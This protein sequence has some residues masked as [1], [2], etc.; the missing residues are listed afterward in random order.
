M[1][2]ANNSIAVVNKKIE[3]LLADAGVDG[4]HIDDILYLLGFD[5][6]SELVIRLRDL[7][8]RSLVREVTGG[9]WK[10]ADPEALKPAIMNGEAGQVESLPSS[11]QEALP[12][13]HLPGSPKFSSYKNTLQ[14]YCQ[15]K[16]LAVPDYKAD[17]ESNGLVGSV[18]FS[19]NTVRSTEVS[20]S[21]KEAH[22]RA[23]FAALV[24]LGY[25]KDAS[26]ELNANNQNKSKKPAETAIVAKPVAKPVLKPGIQEH[27]TFKTLL[28]EVAEKKK[29]PFPTYRTVSVNNKSYFSTVTFDKEEYKCLALY[30]RQEDAEQNAAQVALISLVAAP[31][32]E[33][34]KRKEAGDFVAP[35]AKQAKANSTTP[36]SSSFKSQL[37]ELA[38]KQSIPMPTYDTVAVNGG[39]FS[40]VTF[41]NTNFKSM[42]TKSKRKEAEQNA[43][44]VALNAIVGI[45]LPAAE[46]APMAINESDVTDMVNEARK[47][48]QPVPL[49]NRLQE[50]CQRLAKALPVYVNELDEEQKMYRSTVTVQEVEYTGPLVK[51]KK[52][53]ETAAAE[54]ALRALEL[55]A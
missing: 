15:K 34:L 10:K 53:A 21:V 43:A 16:H 29:L 11:L 50:Y 49:K 40:T 52:Q 8:N 30:R 27:I 28:E 32:P 3:N 13:V 7:K 45:P 20:G 41:N 54:T 39:F 25:L 46:E 9:R 12:D 35:A 38:Q 31:Q 44:Q 48:A 24:Q 19:L 23:A 42:A 6:K 33:E 4:L 51:G 5:T 2:A 36:V 26:F 37:N 18:N 47:A 55:M 17:H 14:E 22:S 1:A